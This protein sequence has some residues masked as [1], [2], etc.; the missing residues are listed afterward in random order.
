MREETRAMAN[1]LNLGEILAT[2]ARVTPDRIGARDLTRAMT[3]RDWN[4][5]ACRLANA[6]LGLGLRKGD[7]TAVLAFN[8][9]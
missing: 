7:R 5:R 4:A 1:L 6:L 3:F 8:C 9:L 2:H